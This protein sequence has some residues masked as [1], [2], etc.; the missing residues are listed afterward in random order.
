VSRLQ[1][2]KYLI[3]E[4]DYD[5]MYQLQRA[6]KKGV[7]TGILRKEGHSSF[8]LIGAAAAAV[9]DSPIATTTT[10]PPV[11]E[12][13]E[14]KVTCIDLVVGKGDV[15]TERGDSLT[16]KYVG[17]LQDDTMF[18]AESSFEFTLGA[19]DV[20]AGWD[21]GDALLGLKVGGKR[22]LIVPPKLGYDNS[23]SSRGPDIPPDST[24]YFEI[25]LRQLTKGGASSS[26][27]L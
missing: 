9:D 16:V 20:L 6:L 12:E 2:H 17:K 27:L 4:L 8:V 10:T 15:C 22:K 3:A 18:D 11:A 21:Q 23:G 13:E 7:D 5:N 14:E 25:T 24:L 26:P 1:I 19:G